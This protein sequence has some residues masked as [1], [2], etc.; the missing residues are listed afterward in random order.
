[1]PERHA[2]RPEIQQIPAVT[3][4]PELG[5]RIVFA[6]QA[7]ISTADRFRL[8][9][10]RLRELAKSGKL[11]TLLVTSALPNDGKSTITLN[12]AAALAEHGDQAVLVLEA[13]LRRSALGKKLGLDSWPG[14][15]EC[16][17]GS[18]DPMSAIR[19]IEP[20]GWYLL[21]A[22]KKGA[23]ALQLLQTEVISALLNR[24]STFFDWILIDSPP[25][26]LVTDSVALSHYADATL[27]VARAGFTPRDSIEE[28]IQA[29]GRN[30][31]LGIVLNGVEGLNPSYAKYYRSY[32]SHSTAEP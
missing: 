11:R 4:K 25:A 21:P 24:L 23:E 7:F 5:A 13:D 6:A 14:L 2:E 26:L 28:A 31:V 8:L 22:G 1:M 15:A 17:E 27:L 32:Y 12:L 20:Q 9:R 16:L 18:L 10:M 30:R 29:I 3:A 19:R